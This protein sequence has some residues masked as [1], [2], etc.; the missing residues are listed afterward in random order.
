MAIRYSAESVREIQART[1]ALG[2]AVL[3]DSC[4]IVTWSGGHRYCGRCPSCRHIEL[5]EVGLD[6]WSSARL[7]WSYAEKA[8][9]QCGAP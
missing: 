2:D 1:I 5:V 6:P 9:N 7:E 8:A 4:G 3:A